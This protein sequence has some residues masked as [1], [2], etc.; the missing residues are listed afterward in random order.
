MC[1]CVCVC[2]CSDIIYFLDIIQPR[3]EGYA[4]ST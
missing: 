4:K 2:V 1:V 3:N